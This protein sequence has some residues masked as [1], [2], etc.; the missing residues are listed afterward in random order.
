MLPRPFFPRPLRGPDCRA[1][2][3]SPAQAGDLVQP[4]HRRQDRGVLLA[5]GVRAGDAVAV[6]APGRGDLGQLRG[7]RVPGGP[8]LLFQEV[9][10]GQQGRRDARVLRAEPHP[11]QRRG[12]RGELLAAHVPLAQGGKRPRVALPSDHR[13]DDRAGGLVPGQLRHD[14]RQLAQAS[15]SSFSSRCQYRVRPA[16]RSLICRVSSRPCPV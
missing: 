16:V 15:S 2:G 7:D 3:V 9:D 5:A 14:G 12:E 10:R 4:V 13:L 6:D 1:A 11:G 8:E